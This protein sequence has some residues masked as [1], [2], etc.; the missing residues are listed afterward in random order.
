MD[1]ELRLD[2]IA[3]L[4]SSTTSNRANL[5][6]RQLTVVRGIISQIHKVKEN[7]ASISPSM[8]FSASAVID[9]PTIN[10]LLLLVEASTMFFTTSSLYLSSRRSKF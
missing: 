1:G 7:K 10:G 3:S 9:D 5:E 4:E 8:C 6:K 2:G